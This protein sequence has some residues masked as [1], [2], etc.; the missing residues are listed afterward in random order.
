MLLTRVAWELY[1]EGGECGGFDMDAP[2]N[3]EDLQPEDRA[4]PWANPM[5]GKSGGTPIG[6][7][8]GAGKTASG[9]P[10]VGVDRALTR[11]GSIQKLERGQLTSS[12]DTRSGSVS[13]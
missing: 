12:P 5:G 4:A 8:S 9:L 2:D 3:M 11:S 7:S 1:G 13:P 6:W 10:S